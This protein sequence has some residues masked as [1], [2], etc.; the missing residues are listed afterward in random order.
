M[1]LVERAGESE[2]DSS[3]INSL[4]LVNA[5]R[6][7]ANISRLS[8]RTLAIA[9]LLATSGCQMFQ[10]GQ[11]IS[12]APAFVDAP[13]NFSFFAS[14]RYAAFPPRRVLVIPVQT[15]VQPVS[16]QTQFAQ[17]LASQLR[18]AQLFEVVIDP[19]LG[20]CNCDL[21]TILQGRFHEYQ[22][23]ELTE[24]YNCDAILVTRVNRVQGVTPM[25][26]SVTC[27]L[28][29]RGEAVVT[30][31]ADGTWSQAIP[32]TMRS[33]SSWLENNLAAVTPGTLHIYEQSPRHFQSFIA[34]QIARRMAMPLGI[35]TAGKA[36]QPSEIPAKRKFLP[37]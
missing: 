11:E 14:E 5:M 32:G 19:A 35:D 30:T 33:W 26:I 9:L 4:K 16:Y 13:G 27:A 20:F 29:D 8:S 18:S 22:L 25:E 37:F 36:I 7:T 21:D 31:A 24:R 17:E 28:I 12:C 2:Q 23:L 15:A 6:N 3:E 1:F 10:R 34:W